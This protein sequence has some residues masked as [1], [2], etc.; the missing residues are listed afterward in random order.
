MR[1]MLSVGDALAALGVTADLPLT[2]YVMSARW[3]EENRA[4]L[5]AF[6][7]A[8]REAKDILAT[9]DGEWERIAPRTGAAD[10]T[11]L[12]RLRDAYRAGIPRHWDAQVRDSAARL[13]AMLAAIG[14]PALV[15][16]SPDIASGTFFDGVR[17]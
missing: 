17:Y 10:A 2:G 8:S 3:A 16:S 15:G 6:I 5:D 4:V 14:G 11:E 7:A 13:Y 1:R 12:A 9:S